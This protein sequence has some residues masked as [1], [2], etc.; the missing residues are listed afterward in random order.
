[1]RDPELDA[2]VAAIDARERQHLEIYRE[3]F[4]VTPAAGVIVLTS[5]HIWDVTKLFAGMLA[6]TRGKLQNTVL[7]DRVHPHDR[8]RTELTFQSL[9]LSQQALKTPFRNRYQADDGTYVPV[10]WAP[11]W[12]AWGQGFRVAFCQPTAVG[13]LR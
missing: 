8:A 11:G 13:R 3:A 2:I 12:E 6:S 1:M 4:A 7:F 10:V 5:G 9:Q